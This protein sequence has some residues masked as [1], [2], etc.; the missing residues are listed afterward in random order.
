MTGQEDEEP[1]RSEGIPL[2]RAGEAHEIAA[3]VAFL[4]GPGASYI[5][6]SS[7]VVDGGLSLTA[8]VD[9]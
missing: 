5:T 2:G 1:D 3:M 8:A 4:A 6:G 7:F 9:Q